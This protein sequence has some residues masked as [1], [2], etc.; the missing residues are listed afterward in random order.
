MKDLPENAKMFFNE[1]FEKVIYPEDFIFVERLKDNLQLRN[2]VYLKLDS[3]LKDWQ[4]WE[5]FLTL[6]VDCASLMQNEKTKEARTLKRQAE[7]LKK[8]IEICC[9]KLAYSI[10]EI[11]ELGEQGFIDIPYISNPVRTVIEAG[12]NNILFNKYINE[13]LQKAIAGFSD[14]KY[15]PTIQDV[16]RYI[17]SSYEEQQIE[18]SYNYS[19]LNKRASPRD[20]CVKLNRCIDEHIRSMALPNNFKLTHSEIAD[21]CNALLLSDENNITADNV[22]TYLN[23]FKKAQKRD[24]LDE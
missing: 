18:Y 11:N 23:D 4:N 5:R 10:D 13:N 8:D 6:V 12:K 19:E 3:H 21:F 14:S 1:R 7:K 9:E 15:L 16:I 20:F 2:F 22:K 17:S 24:L